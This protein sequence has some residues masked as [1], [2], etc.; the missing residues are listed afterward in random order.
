MYDTEHM[1]IPPS[2][3]ANRLRDARTWR[4]LTQD[5]IATILGIARTSVSKYEQGVTTPN[6]LVMLAW[7]V[8]CDV[9][10]QW[11]QTGEMNP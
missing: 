2:T 11:L 9:D 7:A 10:A 3:L 4:R 6:R 1:N 8:A 5:D